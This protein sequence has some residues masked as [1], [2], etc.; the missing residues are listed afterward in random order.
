MIFDELQEIIVDKLGVD[1]SE[2]TM[3]SNIK[4]DLKADSL[5]LFE[6]ITGI[7]EQYDIEI[8]TDDL[9]DMATV[10]DMVSYIE[11]ATQE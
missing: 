3:E 6:I 1:E 2:V 9:K 11:K 5:D 8:P 10:A 4:D 7:E